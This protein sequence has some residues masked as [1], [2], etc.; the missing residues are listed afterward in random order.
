MAFR[1]DGVVFQSSLKHPLSVHVGD[2]GIV[3]MMVEA[4]DVHNDL[5]RPD[6][7]V[8]LAQPDVLGGLSWAH[9]SIEALLRFA[10]QE[11]GVFAHL[12]QLFLA[13]DWSVA[14]HDR[15]DV[16]R[17]DLVDGLQPLDDVSALEKWHDVEKS[18]VADPHDLMLG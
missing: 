7:V 1:L 17:I 5:L 13:A 6:P 15:L 11:P 18:Y 12:R 10:H 4:D 3:E 16:H 8:E 14:W 2:N 9:A